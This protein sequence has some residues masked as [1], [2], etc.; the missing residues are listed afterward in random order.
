MAGVKPENCMY[1][2][3]ISCY[4]LGRERGLTDTTCQGAALLVDRMV[5]PRIL[6][7]NRDGEVCDALFAAGE[8]HP[9][10]FFNEG[11]W[12]ELKALA[13][14]VL[15]TLGKASAACLCAV[16][17]YGLWIVTPA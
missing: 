6:E 15:L 16:A 9:G 1:D 10:R 12:D 14:D 5:D 2:P 17:L 3:F 7:G 13:R 8:Q 4:R 11:Q